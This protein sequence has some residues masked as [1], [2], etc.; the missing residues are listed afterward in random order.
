MRD[1]YL[2]IDVGT[3]GLRAALV[4]TAGKVLAISHREHEQIVPQFGWSEQRPADWWTGTI[5]SIRDVLE[6]VDNAAARVAAI[7][8]CGQMH[9]S[10]LVDANGDLTREAALLWND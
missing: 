3:G 6:R 4:D 7:C 5:A 10:V 1:L 9:G 2:A 8:T